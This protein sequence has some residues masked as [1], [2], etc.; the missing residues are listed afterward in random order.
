MTQKPALSRGAQIGSW[1]MWL[2]T[3]PFLVFDGV[4]KVIQ[5]SHAVEATV[6]LGFS[7]SALPVIGALELL[8]L[9]LYLFPS[10][11]VLGA[12]LITGYFGGAMSIQLRAGAQAFSL[13]FPMIIGALLW[14][15]LFIREPRLRALLPWRR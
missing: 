5:E 7:A 1:L 13:V 10:T 11:A 15:A 12:L 4:I 9:A 14:G 6:G 2:V 3:V 8:C